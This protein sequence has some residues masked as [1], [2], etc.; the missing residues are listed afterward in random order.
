MLAWEL[1]A[2]LRGANHGRRALFTLPVAWLLG[3]LAGLSATTATPQPFVA[4]AW[5]LLLGG[6]LTADRK[7]HCA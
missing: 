7:S 3:G 6:L 5:F 2:G 4:A 1:L